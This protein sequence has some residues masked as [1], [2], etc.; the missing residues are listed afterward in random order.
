MGLGWVGIIC[1]PPS[2][3]QTLLPSTFWDFGW[4]FWAPNTHTRGGGSDIDL[5]SVILGGRS[6]PS[7]PLDSRLSAGITRGPTGPPPPGPLLDQRH[8]S[9][10]FGVGGLPIDLSPGGSSLPLQKLVFMEQLS[11]EAD[12][13]IDTPSEGSS[14]GPYPS[15]DGFPESN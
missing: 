5:R 10:T 3:L 11:L 4:V 6:A 15:G 14:F 1:P 2:S 7:P 13:H 9:A 8:S 12:L